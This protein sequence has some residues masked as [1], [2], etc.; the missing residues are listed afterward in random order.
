MQTEARREGAQKL[1]VDDGRAAVREHSLIRVGHQAEEVVRCDQIEHG[2]AKKLKP[3]VVVL[4][5]G[6]EDRFLSERP[7]VHAQ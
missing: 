4:D 1:I 6:C 2:I 3:L 7:L 5:A